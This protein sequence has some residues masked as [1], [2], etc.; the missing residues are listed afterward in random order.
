MNSFYK[1]KN[2]K[3]AQYHV[4]DLTLYKTKKE[5][6]MFFISLVMQILLSSLLF[7]GSKD[8]EIENGED[9]NYFLAMCH[10]I[11]LI[12]PRILSLPKYKEINVPNFHLLFKESQ[13]LVAEKLKNKK[14]LKLIDLFEKIVEI[15]N[16]LNLHF[17]KKYILEV[18]K[19]F[20]FYCPFKTDKFS[21]NY[22]KDFKEYIKKSYHVFDLYNKKKFLEKRF[23]YYSGLWTIQ[24][25]LYRNMEK[26]ELNN[27]DKDTI[28]FFNYII[29]FILPCSECSTHF[30]KML[31]KHPP[32][33]DNGIVLFRWSIDRHN[34]VN[35]RLKKPTWSLSDAFYYYDF[36]PIPKNAIIRSE[37][38]AKNS[39]LCKKC[40]NN[41][42]KNK[43]DLKPGERVVINGEDVT[44]QYLKDRSVEDEKV[45]DENKGMVKTI[46][47]DNFYLFLVLSVVSIAL[48]IFTMSMAGIAIFKPLTQKTKNKKI[49][50]N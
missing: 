13:N 33:L 16:K 39:E 28:K 49:I 6:E 42:S 24:H 30:S 20:D 46:K 48:I 38:E 5:R 32:P 3:K 10:D 18:D 14:S 12:F 26:G 29:E 17:G 9:K 23:F 47:D 43:L 22:W 37:K 41:N 40:T 35:I 31:E 2:E 21:Q 15:D 25:M 4:I 1:K 45:N 44:K 11:T 19:A 36:Q 27:E 8:Y 50:N 34:D 7:F